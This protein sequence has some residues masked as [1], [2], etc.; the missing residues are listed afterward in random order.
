[1]V[2]LTD[3]P[4]EILAIIADHTFEGLRFKASPRSNPQ[5]HRRAT[6]KVI[7]PK[8][9]SLLF[10]AKKNGLAE[11]AKKSLANNSFAI[12][13][14]YGFQSWKWSPSFKIAKEI[15]HLHIHLALVNEMQAIFLPEIIPQLTSLQ[16]IKIERVHCGC[17]HDVSVEDVL[18]GT[19]ASGSMYGQHICTNLEGLIRAH[20]VGKNKAPLKDTVAIANLD[21]IEIDVDIVLLYCLTSIRH[22][23]QERQVCFAIFQQSHH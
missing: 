5:G 8:A 11:I 3:L 14:V 1:M 22:H 20:V 2:K 19:P 17:W 9:F 23:T 7:V 10:V 13:S 4:V 12:N 16:Y 6:R 15:K 21:K 18:S